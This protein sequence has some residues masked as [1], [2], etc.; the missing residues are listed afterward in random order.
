MKR[1]KKVYE[2]FFCYAV[3][4]GDQEFSTKK[5]FA[6][7]FAFF[8]GVVN[9]L[10]LMFAPVTHW[11]VSLNQAGIDST[12]LGI[13]IGAIEGLIVSSLAIYGYSKAK[14]V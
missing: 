6:F 5:F 4:G 3:N 2:A 7:M 14:G 11:I 8:L 12:A 1:L 13:I 9:H 10:W